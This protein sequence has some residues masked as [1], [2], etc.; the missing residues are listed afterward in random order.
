MSYVRAEAL[1][2][3]DRA[4]LLGL[5]AQAIQYFLDNQTPSGLVLDRQRNVGPR[6]DFGVCSLAATGMG[7]IGLALASAPSFR[8]LTHDDAVRRVAAGLRTCLDH[9]PH[10]HGVLPHFVDATT[11]AAH[12]ADP[13]S[14]VE[15]GWLAAGA[16]WAAGFLRDRVLTDL[17]GQLYDR[18]DWRRW[19]GRDGLLRHGADAE[20]RPINWVWDRLNGET[21]FLYVLAAGA[22]EDRALPPSCWSELG[23]FESEAGGL[24][25]ASADLGLFVFQYGLDL[26]DL[27]AWRA[28]GGPDLPA[29][30]ALAVEANRRVCRSAAARFLTYHR[31]WGLSAGDGPSD[32][33]DHAYRDYAPAGPIDGTAHL[34]AAAASVAHD[35]GAVL[36]NLYEAERDASLAARGRYGFSNVNVDREWVGKDMVGIDAGALML[37][38]DNF[39]AADRVRAVFHDVPCVAAGCERLGFTRF[40][41]PR[42]VA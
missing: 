24:R 15:T 11:F 32:A 18:I 36:Q 13:R 39:L 30:A 42:L 31:F 9:A 7:F 8:L 33:A 10:D 26:L 40:V 22:N 35:P 19:T 4:F 20:G 29:T 28:P 21:V 3:C 41:P 17:A 23:A 2:R 25:F 12:G 34:T 6:R 38:L 27:S 1:S 5:Q 37:A 16:L 14:T